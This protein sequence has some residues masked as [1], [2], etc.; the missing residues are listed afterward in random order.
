MNSKS[1]EKIIRDRIYRLHGKEAQQLTWDILIQHYSDLQTP[2]MQ[3]DLGNDCYTL[4]GKMFF[5]CY[6]IENAKYDNKETEKKIKDDYQKFT[7]EW[8]PNLGN[9]VENWIFFTKDNLMGI[10]HQQIATLNSMADRVK[11]EQW[12]LEQLVNLCLKLPKDTLR[13]IFNLEGIEEATLN[14]HFENNAPNH[15]NQIIATNVY[16]QSE[17]ESTDEIVIIDEIFSYVLATLKGY[18]G[19]NANGYLHLEEKIKLNF[20]NEADR[21]AV[22]RY[23]KFA[24]TKVRLIE[25]RVQEAE[26]E[27]Q[28]DLQGHV[29]GKY[30]E[31]KSKKMSNVDILHELF[32]IFVPK[33]KERNSQYVNLAKAFVLF[34][35]E[36]CSIFEK[37][38]TE[39]G[40]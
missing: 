23:F 17:V 38:K 33:H 18:D 2:K 10:P 7:T 35:F 26:P 21:E 8:K 9:K 13:Q 16:I 4:E 14:Q 34:Y 11:K 20:I 6:F 37:T 1:L 36:D 22:E 25:Q 31:L 30:Y 32:N 27:I 39:S 5:A 28:N 24:L 3:H 19:T 40:K 29:F 12:G 15:G